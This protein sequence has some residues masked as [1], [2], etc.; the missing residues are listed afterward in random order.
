MKT[1]LVLML[2]CGLISVPTSS[3][4]QASPSRPVVLVTSQN[5]LDTSTA[6]AGAATHVGRVVVGGAG[7]Q[8][9][10]YVHSEVWEVVRRFS[11]ECPA[12]TF[13]TNPETPHAMTIHTDY[14]KV[15][16]MVV[17]TIALYQLALLDRD[18]NPL[19]VAKKNYLRRQIKPICGVIQQQPR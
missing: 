8:S 6:A 11:E 1:S 10:I 14:Q 19:Y 9:S 17:G 12:A 7:A 2:F 5:E 18:G 3:S 15:H 4:G 16:S 13:V